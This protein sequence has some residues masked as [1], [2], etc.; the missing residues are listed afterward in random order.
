MYYWRFLVS[1]RQ[2]NSIMNRNQ[3]RNCHRTR[4]QLPEKPHDLDWTETNYVLWSICMKRAREKY[5]EN[6]A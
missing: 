1:D 6:E 2:G 4:Y 5:P 3:E